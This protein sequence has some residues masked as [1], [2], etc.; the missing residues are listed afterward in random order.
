MFA[1]AVLVVT[2]DPSNIT[3]KIFESVRLVCNTTGS[4]ESTFVWEHDGSIIMTSNSTSQQDSLKINSVMPWHQ[5][6]YKCSVRSFYS[7]LNSYALATLILNG[8]CI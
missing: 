8:N 2:I 7:S 1:E 4:G 5:G 6:Q 3:A